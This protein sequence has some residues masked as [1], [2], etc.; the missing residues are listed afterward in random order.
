MTPLS[1]L[2]QT[3]ASVMVH[4]TYSEVQAS[5]LGLV[6]ELLLAAGTQES[7]KT[8]NAMMDPVATLVILFVTVS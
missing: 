5:V 2:V 3:V 7:L 6:K 8:I 1:L 4:A